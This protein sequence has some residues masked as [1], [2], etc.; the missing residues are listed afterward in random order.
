MVANICVLGLVAVAASGTFAASP[1][2]RASSSSLSSSSSALSASSLRSLRSLRSSLENL[3][4]SLGRQQLYGRA[5]NHPATTI[6]STASTFP[7]R[8]RHSNIRRSNNLATFGL[9]RCRANAESE[10]GEDTAAAPPLPGFAQRVDDKDVELNL[11]EIWGRFGVRPKWNEAK[12][13]IVQDAVAGRGLYVRGDQTVK[14][15]DTLLSVP[16]RYAIT[17]SLDPDN[18]DGTD[19][20][21][22]LRLIATLRSAQQS[23]TAE[24]DAEPGSNED[25]LTTAKNSLW[26]WYANNVL[27]SMESLKLGA[28]WTDED[29]EELQHEPSIGAAL[30]F[31][32]RFRKFAEFAGRRDLALSS[33]QE[34]KSDNADELADVAG[35]STEE[36]LLWALGIVNSRSF[37]A[38]VR[39]GE[40]V[41]D[42]RDR[43]EEETKTEIVR[44]LCPIV[45]LFNHKSESPSEALESEGK[46]YWG[47]G[48]SSDMYGEKAFTI[49][50]PNEYYP[51]EEIFLPYGA[52]TNLELLMAYGFLPP[53]LE[54][55]TV[56]SNPGD[57]I[58]MF[59]DVSHLVSSVQIL[60]NLTDEQVDERISLLSG[61][62]ACEAP[63]AVR[64]GVL[65]SSDHLIGCLA[66]AL[67]PDDKLEWMREHL[68]IDA[69][70]EVIKVVAPEEADEQARSEALT[71]R[72][73]AIR[74]A[75]EC[76][77]Q[78]LCAMPTQLKEDENLLQEMEKNEDA[79]SRLMEAVSYRLG[80]KKLLVEFYTVA[81]LDWE[82]LGGQLNSPPA[83]LV[84]STGGRGFDDF[85]L[86]WNFES[87]IMEAEEANRE[88][89]Q[90]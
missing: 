1:F 22:A 31:A 68:S 9:R 16:F 75:M 80:V 67:A 13:E 10:T 90:V 72:A 83:F 85:D 49:L 17:V 89:K 12:L 71:L 2:T 48:R 57:Y 64:P 66:L 29:L 70:H 45:D 87:A 76:V 36:E 44:M 25:K 46:N 18:P 82:R 28:F 65:E 27:P 19:F 58:T 86:D 53:S 60:A 78:M 61:L 20:E 88:Q 30:Q 43:Q 11:E 73:N 74:V 52:E 38:A 34:T 84:R 7:A 21:L 50:A 56:G 69:G 24:G 33:L 79:D 40:V 41:A 6:T 23:S 35:S 63:L 26:L 81:A 62:S 59:G 32:H 4:S 47:V 54:P 3:A 14:E 55:G 15:G 42:V 39:D 8:N 77:D 37:A 51:R 5:Q